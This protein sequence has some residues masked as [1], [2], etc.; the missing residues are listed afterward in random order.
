MAMEKVEEAI[1]VVCRHCGVSDD[2]EDVSSPSPIRGPKLKLHGPVF[3]FGLVVLGLKLFF[4]LNPIFAVIT[5]SEYCVL[6]QSTLKVRSK[7]F[8]LLVQL[9]ISYDWVVKD[10]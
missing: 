10:C 9:I 4:F 2:R 5:P 3:A 6:R 8:F 7:P 1:L